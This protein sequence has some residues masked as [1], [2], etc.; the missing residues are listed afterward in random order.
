MYSKRASA[1]AIECNLKV[2]PELRARHSEGGQ[3]DGMGWLL[4]FLA[5]PWSPEPAILSVGVPAVSPGFIGWIP[6]GVVLAIAGTAEW[7]A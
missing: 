1:L 5:G 4:A 6:A 3:S 7:I 2:K